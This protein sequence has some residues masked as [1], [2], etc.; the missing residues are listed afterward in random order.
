M[1]FTEQTLGTVVL[2]LDIQAGTFN[3]SHE[4]IL[5]SQLIFTFELLIRKVKSYFHSILEIIVNL[6]PSFQEELIEL[7]SPVSAHGCYGICSE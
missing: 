3:C 1:R 7:H 2:S 6:V 5:L 4:W